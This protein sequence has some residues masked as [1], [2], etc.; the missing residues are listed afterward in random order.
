[1]KP[2]RIEELLVGTPYADRTSTDRTE[3][4]VEARRITTWREI[5]GEKA[6]MDDRYLNAARVQLLAKALRVARN[7]MKAEGFITTARY[8]DATL[9]EA[10]LNEQKEG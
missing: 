8:V 10:G 7:I 1:M 6:V 4:D 2:E 3:V 5:A 9:T